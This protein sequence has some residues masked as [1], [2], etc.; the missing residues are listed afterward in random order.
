MTAD[1]LSVKTDEGPTMSIRELVCECG[2]QAGIDPSWRAARLARWMV[3]ADWHWP[4]AAGRYLG[5]GLMDAVCPD[6][7]ARRV[8]NGPIVE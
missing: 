7:H 3:D 5:M 4:T 8:A 1:R 6:C 2:R